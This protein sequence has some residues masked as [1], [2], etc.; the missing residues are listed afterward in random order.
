MTTSVSNTS[1]S[2][3]GFKMS[4]HEIKIILAFCIARE[5]NGF[6]KTLTSPHLLVILSLIK[7]FFLLMMRSISWRL[8]GPRFRQR[9]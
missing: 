8:L 9:R 5:V 3:T 6:S 7:E 4:K 2:G 1:E